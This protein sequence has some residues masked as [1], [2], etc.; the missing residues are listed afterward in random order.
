MASGKAQIG[1]FAAVDRKD[2]G[3]ERGSGDPDLHHE[4]ALPLRSWAI[5]RAV[6]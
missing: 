1:G 2:G 3:R 5:G 6:Q 4:R